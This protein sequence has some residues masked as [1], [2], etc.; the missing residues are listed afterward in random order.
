MDDKNKAKAYINREMADKYNLF[1]DDLI[2]MESEE[3]KIEVSLE[4]DD[5]ICDDV[6]M[7]YAGWWKKHGNP[8]WIIKSG[9]SDIGGQVTY[10]ETFVKLYKQTSK[11]EQKE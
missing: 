11:G 6:V 7:M 5:S 10:N 1:E 4:I 3:G 2:N 8:N 9:I